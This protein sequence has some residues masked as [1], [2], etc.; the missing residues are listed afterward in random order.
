MRRRN[1][2]AL[3]DAGIDFIP[4]NDFSLYDH[5]LD[6]AVAVGA[7]PHRFTSGDPPSD[8]ALYFAMA[9]G[10]DFGA[11]PV[12][13]L[14]LT[15]WFDTNY[16]HLVPEIGPAVTFQASPT[17][18]CAELE[19]SAALGVATVPV[20]LGPFTLLSR[21][22][23]A[24]AGFD[25][26][27]TLST[28]GEAYA[29]H[30]AE[31]A[32]HG[33][34]WVRLDE[35]ALTEDRDDR[36]LAAIRKVYQRL[37]SVPKRPKL[38]LATYFGHVGESMDVLR[39]LPVEG[40]GLDFCHGPENSRLLERTGGVAEKVLFAG[41]VDG[42]NV[43]VNDLEA[44]LN[45]LDRL[46]SL[47][48]ELVVSTSCSLLHVPVSLAAE[49][50]LDARVRPWLAFAEEKIA[51]IAVLARGAEEGRAAISAELHANRAVLEARR[52]SP[53]V[54][55]PALRQ[56]V[57]DAPPDPRRVPRHERAAAQQA[58]LG[59]P[60]LPTT[61]IGSLPQT[62]HLRSVRAGWRAGRVSDDEYETSVRSEIDRV[63]A[64]Q[65][66]L[67]MDVMVHGEPERDDMVRYFAARLDGYA[68]TDNGWVQ[69]YGSRCVRP[70]ILYGEVS[71]PHPISVEW[72]RYAQSRTTRPVKGML[73]G[74]VTMLRWSFVRDDLP[75]SETA[76]QLALA[77]RE[78]L[79]DLQQAGIV[80]V[81]VD[82]PALREGMPLRRDEQPSYLAWASRTFRLVTSSA[83]TA[84][85]VHTHM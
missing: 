14:D 19:E 29:E 71:R 44:S 46:G 1:W 30:L 15:K 69:S 4:S 11:G 51:E 48:R 78:E 85:Q 12:P 81:Q 76:A 36:D 35:P 79:L 59:L 22:T 42:R 74:P 70:P 18:S 39:E 75:Q 41:V 84:T 53:L 43:W 5:V 57:A 52:T 27:G 77:V 67:G 2:E 6:A 20:L 31:L 33:A 24:A 60:A 13:P 32:R 3:R 66:R 9:R 83:D 21:S 61:M 68:L 55:D 38:L 10:G 54:S 58:R 56:A 47:C 62:P 64:F 34:D 65:E 73:T 8:L 26:M 16:H 80:A 40:I 17:K 63:I 23:P 82:E 50:R 37:A 49:T 25:V 28:L 7:I 45:L 72:A